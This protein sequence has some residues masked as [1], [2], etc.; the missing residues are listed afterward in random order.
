MRY[1][2]IAKTCC[3]MIFTLAAPHSVV[4]QTQTQK[5]DGYI[6]YTTP[7]AAPEPVRAPSYVGVLLGGNGDVDEATRALCDHSGGGDLVV[8]R[9]SYADEYNAELHAACPQN[10]VTTLVITT[11]EGAS[12]PF[13]AEALRDAHAIFIAGGDQSNYV[14]FWTGNPVQTEINNALAR[15]VPLGGVS[16]GLAVQGEF[17]F[18]SMIDTIT[19]PEAMADP[20]GPRVTLTREFLS[21]PVL[22]GIITDSHFSQR[23]RMGRSIVFMSRIVQDGWASSVHGI[24]IDETTAVVVEADGQARVAGKGAAYFLTLDHQPE[25]C[26]FGRPLTV[27]HVKVVKVQAGPDAKFDLKSWTRTGPQ[28]FEVNI[29]GGKIARSD[30]PN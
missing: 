5:G 10:T 26:A 23:E 24:G 29:I 18:S 19:S 7:A 17:A 30:Q 8:L 4:V 12:Q 20:Y 22:K 3:V 13:V 27:R 21:I 2:P 14:R 11:R 6:A 28:Q 25:E 9:A 16:A 15:G 1:H